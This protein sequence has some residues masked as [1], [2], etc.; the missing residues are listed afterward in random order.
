M[1]V[2]WGPFFQKFRYFIV[3]VCNNPF[4]VEFDFKH[5]N[6]QI[7]LQFIVVVFADHT[8]LLFFMLK[9]LAV[10]FCKCSVL[11]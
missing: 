10:Y 8:H 5:R 3:D 7:Y 6:K 2:E 1:I 9:C 4:T 11:R